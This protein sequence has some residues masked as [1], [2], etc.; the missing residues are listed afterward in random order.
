MAAAYLPA[1]SIKHRLKHPMLVGI[2]LWAIGTS[3]PMATLPRS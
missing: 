2:I 3:W 1:G